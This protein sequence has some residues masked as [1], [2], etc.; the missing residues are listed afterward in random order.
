MFTGPRSSDPILSM[1]KS[2]SFP[3]TKKHR[4]SSRNNYK[5]A[6]NTH[7]WTFSTNARIK[8]ACSDRAAVVQ[9]AVTIF[10]KDRLPSRRTVEEKVTWIFVPQKENSEKLAQSPHRERAGA[11]DCTPHFVVSMVTTSLGAPDLSLQTKIRVRRPRD[12][13]TRK[14]SGSYETINPIHCL[15]WWKSHW[16]TLSTRLASVRMCI[17]LGFFLIHFHK[18][19]T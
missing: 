1:T 14:N 2:C 13:M 12:Q 17:S 4:K 8:C 5:P 19:Q 3:Y 6:R 7:H 11:S 10:S 18:E 15:C 16:R 9:A